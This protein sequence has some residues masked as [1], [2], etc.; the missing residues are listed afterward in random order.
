MIHLFG[1]RPSVLGDFHLTSR[2]QKMA[3]ETLAE[4]SVMIMFNKKRCQEGYSKKFNRNKHDLTLNL[5]L[6][7]LTINRSHA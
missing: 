1:V 3:A 7:T 4:S 6:S 5:H 2:V